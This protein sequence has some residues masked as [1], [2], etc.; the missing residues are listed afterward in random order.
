MAAVLGSRPGAVL[1]E[2][3]KKFEEARHGELGELAA[4]YQSAGPPK[5]EAVLVV[6]PPAPDAADLSDEELDTLLIKALKT[7]SVRDAASTV[8]A[9]SGRAR[10]DIY[11]RALE[12]SAGE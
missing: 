6:G 9:A 3:T 11:A 10:R 7:M 5:G 8:A 1:R 4:H 12:I 2:L